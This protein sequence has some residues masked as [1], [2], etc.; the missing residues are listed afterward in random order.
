MGIEGVHDQVGR[1]VTE[2][3]LQSKIHFLDSQHI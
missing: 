1:V 2:K 3:G